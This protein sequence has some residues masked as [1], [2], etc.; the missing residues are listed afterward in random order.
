MNV[1]MFIKTLVYYQKYPKYLN[2]FIPDEGWQAI[3]FVK[4]NIAQNSVILSN[5]FT[6]NVLPAHAPVISF[7][8]HHV[9]TKDFFEKN[10]Q[11]E[12]FYDSKMTESQAKEFLSNNKIQYVFFG[13]GEMKTYS[14]TLSYSFLKEIYNK[15]FYRIYQLQ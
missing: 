6:G 15:D 12:L 2:I 3:K 7:T 8:G 4:E 14:Q 1:E 11:T 5:W 9:H 10:R 13:L